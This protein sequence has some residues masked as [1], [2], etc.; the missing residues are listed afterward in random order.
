MIVALA[1]LSLLP[2][3][4]RSDWGGWQDLDRDCQ[5]TRAE[6]LIE[7]S[8]VP[9]S[10]TNRRQ[11]TVLAGRWH[12][13]YTGGEY[14]WAGSVEID[15]LVPLAE[16]HRSGGWAW[17]AERKAEFANDVENLRITAIRLNRDKGDSDPAGWVPPEGR[18]DY[19]WAWVK[20]KR[21]YGLMYDPAEVAAVFRLLVGC[22]LEEER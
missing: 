22:L 14:E 3:Y 6:L 8:E 15:H 12:D 7:R 9:V 1:L 2:P 21:K 5:D 18:C 11:C 10:Y 13:D 17:P 16:A 4:V 20:V 19:G